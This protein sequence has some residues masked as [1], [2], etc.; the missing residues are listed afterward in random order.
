MSKSWHYKDS[1]KQPAQYSQNP[2]LLYCQNGTTV[3]G[4]L[5]LCILFTSSPQKE[6][7]EEQNKNLNPSF[8]PLWTN[9][10]SKTKREILTEIETGS[11]DIIK[12][13]I[14]IIS[15]I[16][17][18]EVVSI[19]LLLGILLR[20][21]LIDSMREMEKCSKEEWKAGVYVWSDTSSKNNKK[22]YERMIEQRATNK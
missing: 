4:P 3:L 7:L 13:I 12:V 22:R 15:T 9:Q 18:E 14:L 6:L 8:S 17:I 16:I 19:L 20:S 21:F 10:R 1:N 2:I 5:F 11:L